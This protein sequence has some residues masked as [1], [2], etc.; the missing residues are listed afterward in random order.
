MGP[1]MRVAWLTHGAGESQ[2]EQA[3]GLSRLDEQH[4]VLGSMEQ[5][6]GALGGR[7]YV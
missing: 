2:S 7:Q 5:T 1:E 6:Q 4:S 3:E